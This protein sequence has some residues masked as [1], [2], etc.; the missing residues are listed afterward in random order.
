V[1]IPSKTFGTSSSKYTRL[2][3]SDTPNSSATWKSWKYNYKDYMD[4][5]SNSYSIKMTVFWDVALCSLVEVLVNTF[6][7]F[8][9]I[10]YNMVF[11][12]APP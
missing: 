10:K 4:K 11:Q 6:K 8:Y 12:K 7:I 3:K 5:L 9:Y 1:V 2:G